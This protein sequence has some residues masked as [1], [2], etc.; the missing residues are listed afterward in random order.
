MQID[1]FEDV[2]RALREHPEWLEELR[3]LVFTDELIALPSMVAEQGRVQAGHTQTLAEH[4]GRLLSIEEAITRIELRLDDA[5]GYIT[6]ERYRN[7][8]YGY[9]G[10][11]A[12]RIRQLKGPSLEDVLEP[13]EAAGLL[14]EDERLDVL[15]ADGVF[16]G[17]RGDEAARLV[18]EASTV[19]DT[20]DVARAHDRAQIL[21]RAG[22]TTLPIAA[23]KAVTP[24]ARRA[25]RASGVWIVTNGRPETIDPNAA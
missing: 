19:A 8:A 7:K 24:P 5:I 25:A 2:L 12:R 17:R 22:V 16:E 11:I 6:E 23:G 4:S 10:A 13:L 9:F 3:A 20:D 15:A 18:L 1:R 14:E 21:A